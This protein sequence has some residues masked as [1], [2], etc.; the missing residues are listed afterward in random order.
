MH[1]IIISPLNSYDNG[2]YFNGWLKENYPSETGIIPDSTL[3]TLTLN[4]SEILTPATDSA[5][6]AFYHAIDESGVLPALKLLKDSEIDFNTS[7]VIG[8]G[9][10]Y[11]VNQD[12]NNQD[13]KKFSLSL[14]A[15]HN[16]DAIG[17][18]FSD[19]VIQYGYENDCSIKEAYEAVHFGVYDQGYGVRVSTVDGLYYTF[20]D[21]TKLMKFKNFLFGYIKVIYYAGQDIRSDIHDANNILELDAIIDTR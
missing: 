13:I 21:H 18:N 20:T 17:G 9:V 7:L 5:I 1:Q 16:A 10:D 6:I 15:Q 19:N 11:D 3:N 4:F 8:K 2:I 12:E 14:I